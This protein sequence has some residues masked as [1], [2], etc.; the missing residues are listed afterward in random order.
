MI[1][2]SHWPP[3]LLRRRHDRRMSK[4]SALYN[5]ILSSGTSR[6]GPLFAAWLPNGV[7]RNA[8]SLLDV[9]RSVW[10]FVFPISEVW[11]NSRTR[12]RTRSTSS[13]LVLVTSKSP[14]QSNL[15]VTPPPSRPCIRADEPCTEMERLRKQSP[16]IA[17]SGGLHAVQDAF[18]LLRHLRCCTC[19]ME[20]QRH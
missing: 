15:F 17:L 4:R 19:W 7:S 3:D 13:S 18:F 11:R 10:P 12:V 14:I 1:V 2:R 6:A 9:L 16:F 8:G 20:E 5:R